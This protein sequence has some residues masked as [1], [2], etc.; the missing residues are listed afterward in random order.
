MT[1]NVLLDLLLECEPVGFREGLASPEER[2]W[3]AEDETRRD[4]LF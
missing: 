4:A 2:I 3:N 1:V